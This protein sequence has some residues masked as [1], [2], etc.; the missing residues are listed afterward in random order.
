MSASSLAIPSGHAAP[1]YVA[2]WYVLYTLAHHEKRVAR[3]MEERRIENFLPL[4]RALRRW[5]DRTKQLQLPLFP[6]Y[7]FV[8]TSLE[9]RLAILQVPGVVNFVCFSGRPASV[10]QMQIASLRE[11]LEGN[12]WAQPYSYLESGRRVR[13][14]SGPLA[15]LEGILAERRGRLRVVLSVDLIRRSVAVEVGAD[16]I[17]PVL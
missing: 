8:H 9:R 1:L 16:E 10:P 7:L 6:G 3:H 11:M 17:E 2:Q 15:R 12:P 5:A 4:Y 14:R 13:V